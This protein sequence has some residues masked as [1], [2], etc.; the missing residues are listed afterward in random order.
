MYKIPFFPRPGDDFL[1][2]LPH[3][4]ID[5][6]D[7]IGPQTEILIGNMKDE[8]SFFL[9]LFFPDVFK[10]DLDT[11]D[12]SIHPKHSKLRHASH[13][14]PNITLDQAKYYISQAYSFIPENQAQLMSEFFLL[15]LNNDTSQKSLLKATYDII[16]DSGFVCPAVVLS[17]Q[18]SNY[19]VSVYHY[20]I[21]ERPTNSDWHPWMG[22]THLDEVQLVF[23]FPI[24][25]PKNY[26]Q[27]EI[28]FSWNL[29][30]TWTT[31]A[32]TGLVLIWSVDL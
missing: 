31:F 25:Y 21:T 19:N 8:G 13:A 24:K 12:G 5:D 28:D 1:P 22:S 2:E 20:L 6:V 18:M 16:G 30:N 4:A 32:K 10:S 17:E 15:S 23:G 14:I 9:H 7:A 27:E 29:I 26:T 11:S 3:E